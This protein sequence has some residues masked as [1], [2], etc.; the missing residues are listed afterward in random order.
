MMSYSAI[1]GDISPFFE[2]GTNLTKEFPTD[3]LRGY[4][5]AIGHP[6]L[7]LRDA[8]L[9]WQEDK[10]QR[11]GHSWASFRLTPAGLAAVKELRARFDLGGLNR[12]ELSP[13][14]D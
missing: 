9:R 13:F 7:E 12:C 5:M 4:L 6:E 8:L 2:I 3:R 11:T 1:D 10:F 14:G